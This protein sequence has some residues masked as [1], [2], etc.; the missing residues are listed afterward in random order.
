MFHYV[1][2]ELDYLIYQDTSGCSVLLGMGSKV[3]CAI[4]TATWFCLRG[5]CEWIAYHPSSRFTKLSGSMGSVFILRCLR[6]SPLLLS[7][8]SLSG[9]IADRAS[10]V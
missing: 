2:H 5:G 9:D 4:S 1:S 7:L 8:G 6:L 10:S 3:K